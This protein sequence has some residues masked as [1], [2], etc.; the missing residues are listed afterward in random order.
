MLA[1]PTNDVI[2]V[3]SGAS[4]SW[5]VRELTEGGLKVVLFEAGRNLDIAHD[6]LPTQ[7]WAGAGLWGASNRRFRA[8]RFRRHANVVGPSLAEN[9]EENR[10]A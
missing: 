2:V 3:G 5:A 10:W 4:G 6:V 8:S 7:R 1:K 9:L